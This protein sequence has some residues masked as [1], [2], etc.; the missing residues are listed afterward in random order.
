MSRSFIAPPRVDICAWT[1]PAGKGTRRAGARGVRRGACVRTGAASVAADL[2]VVHHDV[3]VDLPEHRSERALEVAIT[4]L[5]VGDLVR[6]VGAVRALGEPAGRDLGVLRDLD[7]L[8]VVD[9]TELLGDQDRA[10]VAVVDTL[11]VA[12]AIETGHEVCVAAAPLLVERDAIVGGRGGHRG[13][14]SGERDQ[15]RC[16]DGDDGTDHVTHRGSPG[17]KAAARWRPSSK[18]RSRPAARG[19][20]ARGRSAW[21]KA[22]SQ[23]WTIV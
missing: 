18:P 8:L 15:Q 7:A 14:R 20:G 21:A 11:E 16:G 1:H 23:D 6:D 3:E 5:G 13:R 10:R 2:L 12:A 9:G 4:N 22:G 17:L 19:L